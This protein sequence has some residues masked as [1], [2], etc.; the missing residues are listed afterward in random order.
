VFC[1]NFW[2][3]SSSWGSSGGGPHDAARGLETGSTFPHDG[4][5]I[6]LLTLFR[7]GLY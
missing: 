3:S 4:R 6:S 1:F 7:H 5:M 2:P